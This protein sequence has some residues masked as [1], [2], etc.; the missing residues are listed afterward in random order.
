MNRWIV[1]RELAQPYGC[2]YFRVII[3]LKFLVKSLLHSA[4]LRKHF[5]EREQRFSK[6]NNF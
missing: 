6:E 2:D 1:Y 5:F 4:F 3:S